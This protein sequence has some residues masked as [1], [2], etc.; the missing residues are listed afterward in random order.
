MCECVYVSV[1]VCRLVSEGACVAVLWSVRKFV[2]M[3]VS[4]CVC[5]FV[6]MSVHVYVRFMK[7][8]VRVCADCAPLGPS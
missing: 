8:C 4:W 2:C 5:E 1:C 7:V 6:C 3:Y